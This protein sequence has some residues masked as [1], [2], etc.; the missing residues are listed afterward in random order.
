[1]KALIL[2]DSEVI[3]KLSRQKQRGSNTLELGATFGTYLDE[4]AK[5]GAL[6]EDLAPT[7]HLAILGSVLY[8]FLVMQG[9]LP[10][11]LRTPDERLV[12]LV[13]DTGVRAM[14][15]GAAPTDDD[16][17]A[18][19]QATLDYLDTME[20]I[21]QRKLAFSLGAKERVT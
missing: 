19:R 7:E 8:G 15:S 4:L 1:M 17:R 9:M 5:R 18:I 6:R 14:G 16:E 10:E 11:E 20:E 2:G 3:G 21:A 12:D 13:A